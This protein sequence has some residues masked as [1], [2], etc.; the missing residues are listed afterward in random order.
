MLIGAEGE[1]VIVGL[2]EIVMQPGVQDMA[3][4]V[5]TQGRIDGDQVKIQVGCKTEYF[6]LQDCFDW[7]S[8]VKNA[9]N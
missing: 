7:K 5:I 9:E 8:K 6:F 1:L 3:Q 4:P 2:A